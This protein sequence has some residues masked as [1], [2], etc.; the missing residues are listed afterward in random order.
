MPRAKNDPLKRKSAQALNHLSGAIL[1]V[2]EVYLAFSEQ[3]EKL[4]RVASES[5]DHQ[6][7]ANLER[8]QVYTKDLKTVMMGIAATREHLLMFV[9]NIW[10]LDE[11]SIK[12][13]LG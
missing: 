1:D 11:E 3:V 10:S 9:G 8:Y 5:D 12:V 4:T 6:A 13:Y 2:N 7:Q